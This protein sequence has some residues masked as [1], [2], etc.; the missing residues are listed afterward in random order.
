MPFRILIVD[1]KIDDEMYEIS[2]LPD[3]LRAAGY[4]VRA[5]ADGSEAYDLVW[6]Y[7][8][9][10][11][12]LDIVFENQS[13]DGIDICEAIRLSESELPII[14]VTAFMKETED[15][16]RGF[17]V[18]ADDYVTRPRDNR[19]ILA[20]IRANLPHE[21]VI[22]DDYLLVD[23]AG[24]RVWACRDSSWEEIHLQPLQFELLELL[25]LNARLIVPTT[26]LKDR[27]WGKQVSDDVLAVYIHRL[28]TKLEP[29]P[30]QPMYIE[31]IKTI[32]YR[33]SGRPIRASSNVLEHGCGSVE[34]E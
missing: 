21:V 20:R 13:V 4:E 19:E 1:D 11:V 10:L 23:H 3:M 32:G 24:R 30:A 15:V 6:D 22:V 33:F 27:V 25:I 26:M 29:D 28:R 34:G 16:L 7:H 2:A 18:G 12:V 8:P 31:T 17:E 9:D 14:L 5:T